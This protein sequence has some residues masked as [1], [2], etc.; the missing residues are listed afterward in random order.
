[1]HL[2]YLQDGRD[3]AAL[4]QAARQFSLP[5]R[6]EV[7]ASQGRI[8]RALGERAAAQQA[9]TRAADLTEDPDRRLAFLLDAAYEAYS[10]KA[11][12]DA[13]ELYDRVLVLA[14]D[15]SS[16]RI[17]RAT[18][19]LGLGQPAAAWDELALVLGKYHR[20][21]YW[22]HRFAGDALRA[23]DRP[24]DAIAHYRR[25]LELSPD[26]HDLRYQI[27]LLYERLGQLG[28]A[29]AWWQDY[30]VHQPDG[31]LAADARQRLGMMPD[32]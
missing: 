11:Y 29:R 5:A 13:Q 15:H 16:A 17:H 28:D 9:F 7:L 31:S 26:A 6:P 8:L 24:A 1:M 20:D 14:P 10:R 19:L 3:Q 22:P 30:L 27:G 23:L 4:W 21:E 2:H 32:K 25:A 12:R 18:V